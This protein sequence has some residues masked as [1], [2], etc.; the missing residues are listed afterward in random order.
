MLQTDHL[1]QC[2]ADKHIMLAIGCM[3]SMSTLRSDV[4]AIKDVGSRNLEPASSHVKLSIV[5][6]VL[7]IYFLFS[8]RRRHVLYFNSINFVVSARYDFIVYLALALVEIRNGDAEV[9]D[10]LSAAS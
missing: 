8:E 7:H 6:I 10:N 1:N 2:S 9:K 4:R 3:N 5:C